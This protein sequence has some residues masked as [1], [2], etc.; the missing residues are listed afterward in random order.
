MA[1]LSLSGETTVNDLATRIG[2]DK[3]QISRAVTALV[4]RG[5]LQRS[6]NE[7]DQ[8]SSILRLSEAGEALYE[9]AL[10]LGRE[11]Q[12][13]ILAPLSPEQRRQLYEIMALISSNLR[14]SE[15]T[16]TGDT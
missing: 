7:A 1:I 15:G 11:R 12:H 9:A 5:A 16:D 13:Q 6:A 14:E 2:Y 4:E 10:P 3:S 8:R